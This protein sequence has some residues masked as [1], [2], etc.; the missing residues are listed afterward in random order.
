MA[1]YEN[2]SDSLAHIS[3][4]SEQIKRHVV[5]VEVITLSTILFVGLTQFRPVV[6]ALLGPDAAFLFPFPFLALV[7]WL[8]PVVNPESSIRARIRWGISGLGAGATIGGGITGALSGGL[9]APAGALLGGGIGFVAG[10]VSGPRL[11]GQK[12]VF[13]QGEA[14]EYLIGKHNPKLSIRSI[15][16]A[17]DYPPSGNTTTPIEMFLVD[18]KISCTKADVDAWYKNAAF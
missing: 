17:T 9:G 6:D 14:I 16:A 5:Q 4:L 15:L 1:Q 3:L 11:D 8:T 10:F 7:P 2:A 18:G 12:S 13:T